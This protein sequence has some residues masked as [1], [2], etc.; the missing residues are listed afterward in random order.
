[1]SPRVRAPL[2]L[3]VVRRSRIQQIFGR[4]GEGIIITRVYAV[5]RVADIVSTNYIEPFLCFELCAVFYAI[6]WS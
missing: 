1:M 4:M 6:I 3:G 5:K 2:Q